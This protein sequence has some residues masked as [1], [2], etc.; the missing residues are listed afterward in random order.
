[1]YLKLKLVNVHHSLLLNDKRWYLPTS[2]DT[3]LSSLN[4]QYA[5]MVSFKPQYFVLA[6][7]FWLW[8]TCIHVTSE[9]NSLKPG[10]RLKSTTLLSSENGY[11][12]IQFKKISNRYYLLICGPKKENWEVWIGNRN[13]PVDTHARLLLSHSGVLKIE[14]KHV[15]PIILY[16]SPQ[17]S[18]NTV[19]TLLD[20]GN[21]VLQQL[22]PNGTNT[23]LWQSFDYP[24]NTLLPGMKLGVNHKSGHKWSLVSWLTTEEPSV[25]AFELEWEPT[26]RELMIKRRGKLCWA[27][28]KLGN[29]GFMHDTHYVIVS[30]ENESYFSIT[31]FSEELTIWALLETGQLINRNGVDNNVARADLCY[32]YNKD[33]GCQ[34]W[35][36]IPLCRHRGDVFDSR[37]GYPNENMATHLANSSYGL[38]DCQDM[39]WRNCT[40]FGFTYF[41]D[42]DGTGCVFFQWN[43]TK[44]TNVASGGNKFFVLANKS[45]NK[46]PTVT[47]HKCKLVC[48]ANLVNV[49]H[50]LLLNDK[51][52]YLPTSGDTKLSSLNFQ[53]AK[54]VSFK[55]QYFVLA[56][57][58]WL[59]I[60]CIHV[61]SE[62][63]SLK[64]GERLKSTT[65]L[66]SENGYY[67]IQFKKISNRYYLLICGPKK[68]NWEVW[69]GNRNQPVDTHARLLLSHSGVLKIESKHVEPIIL[70]SSPQPSENTVATLLDT[71]NF[72]LQQLHPNGTNTT[73]WQS[74]DYPTNTLLPGMKLG[75]NHKSGHK[76]SLVSWLTTE[77]P[78]V[79]AFELEWE[80]TKRELMIKRRGKLCWAN[81]KLGNSGFMHDTHYVIVSN[82][83]ESYF[84]ITTFSEELTIWALLETGQLINRNGVDNNVARADLCYGYNKDEGC[85]RWEE[86][87]LCRHRGDVFDSRVGYPNENMAT[88][89]ANSS[90]GLSDCQDMC[91]RN[92]TC[93]GFT[94]FDDDDGTG[95]VFFQW[96]ST[97]GKK[98]WIWITVVSVVAALLLI[99]AIALAIKKRKRLFEVLAATD[100]FSPENKLGQ[101][102]FGPVYKGILPSG[103]EVAIKRLSKTSR[104]GIV[105][106]KNEVFLICELQHT[107]LVQLLGY[108]IHEEER[109]L[110][111]EF[112]SNKSLDYYLF[113]C[114]RGKVLDWKK[115]FNIIGGISQGLLYL[116]KYSRLKVIHRD[117]K[118]SNILLDE[119]MNP[120][121]SD[122]G[123]ARMFTQEESMTNTS[124]IVGTY[125]YMSP[126]Y[127][128]EGIFSTKS[129]VY[130][131]GV[132]LLEIV[133]GRRNTSFYDDDH[134]L[135]LIGHAW[136][137]WK[138]GALLRLVD[139]SLSE[140]FDLDEVK[141]YSCGS[142]M[143]RTICK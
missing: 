134:P 120:K 40:C 17:P 3:K 118:A 73:L 138:E 82:E 87:P 25:G 78:S 22:H 39:C 96:N 30:N 126:E 43:S 60:T 74:F 100:D 130:S 103:Q 21:F 33:E 34:R 76:W 89:L 83:N 27:N 59:W 65:L 140:S 114:D 104:Q 41:D 93:F 69:I 141:R 67:V 86:I 115:R 139:P 108:C 112:M 137:L 35:E 111:Y 32:G 28:G 2:G 98:M 123:L 136:E 46:E 71:G 91:W 14:S 12:V 94:Y 133:S 70:Y 102:G 125:G 18:E 37:V 16:S 56:L 129:D 121:I 48:T 44:G 5:K 92:C 24:T 124:R 38:S 45:H 122:F 47:S 88:H 81:G 52:W 143:C 7:S 4:F 15:E 106:F 72:V 61:T 142:L 135:N 8:I 51:R 128:M 63:N 10:E 62:K 127:A 84:S 66:S 11:Y 119:N 31:T 1:M 26:K 13:Q 79:G 110:I 75:V 77:E 64:P 42:D 109:I 50:S 54:M 117:L 116:H 36:E 49:H 6:L 80:P 132:L 55:P 9:K 23:T 85:Q 57:S 90:Y 20:T 99:C 95:C 101:G 113:D 53:Y 107:N 29:S 97:K 131:F 105:E 58:F 19:A 68:E